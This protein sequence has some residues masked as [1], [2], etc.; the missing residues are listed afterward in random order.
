[1]QKTFLPGNHTVEEF[2]NALQSYEANVSVESVLILTAGGTTIN[3]EDYDPVLQNSDLSIM[4]AI[5]PEIIYEGKSY[6]EG[7][8]IVGCPQK[9]HVIPITDWESDIEAKIN[10]SIDDINPE[11]KSVWMFIDALVNDKAKLF[12]SLY[13]IYGTIPKYIGGGAGTLDFESFPCVYSNIGMIESG[14]VIGIC[15]INTSV[16]VAHGW[17][18]IT[19]PLKVTESIDNKIVTLDW[20]PALEVYQK[21]VESHSKQPFALEDFMKS[22]KSYPFGISKLNADMVIR[23]PFK[24]EDNCIFTL[25]NIDQGSHVSIMYGNTESLIQGACDAKLKAVDGHNADEVEI[26]IIDCISRVLFLDTLFEKELEGMDHKNKA[27][28]ALTLG[29]IANNGDS[30]LEVFNKTAVVCAIYE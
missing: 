20:E 17:E 7:T 14:A 13:N 11:N 8:I 26:L 28:G 9:L 21:V 27:F 16:G 3:K 19:K 12:D 1:M 25:D 2:A 15:G 23:D 6:Q 22:A 29:E 30:Y 4:G 10:Q 18:P 24:H 5:F